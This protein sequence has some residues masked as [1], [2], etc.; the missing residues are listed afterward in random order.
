M[1]GSGE[2]N[3]EQANAK[4]RSL[5]AGR[6]EWGDT[7][8]D[9]HLR[10]PSKGPGRSPWRGPGDKALPRERRAQTVCVH[11]EEKY[12]ELSGKLIDEVL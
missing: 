6:Q 11:F 12:K 10:M 5:Q 9:A 4:G 3:T 8:K 2:R 7:G 1:P